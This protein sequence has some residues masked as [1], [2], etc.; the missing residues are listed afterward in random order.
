MPDIDPSNSYGTPEGPEIPSAHVTE[1][2]ID[3]PGREHSRSDDDEG[4]GARSKD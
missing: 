1:P 3:S 4:G 2:P